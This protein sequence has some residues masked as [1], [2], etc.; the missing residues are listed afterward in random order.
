MTA[1]RY[2]TSGLDEAQFQPG[3]NETV[4]KNLLGI[5][6]RSELEQVETH[7]LLRTTEAMLDHFDQNHRFR[8]EDIRAMH[9]HWLGDIYP[10]AG[11]YRQVMMSKGGFP[12][13]APAFIS[14]LM[15]AFEQEILARHTPCRGSDY[16]VAES[17]AIVH[18]ELVLIHPFRE[19]NGRLAR[20]LAILMGLQ[21]GL[22]MLVFDEMEGERRE[23][24]FAAV[25]AG[26]GQDYQPMQEI[27]RKI[28]AQSRNEA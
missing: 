13:A 6:R 27:F 24:Y 1:D 2:T 3:S 14:K 8:A 16:T 21:A 5:T 11:N 22:P 17:L 18:V 4:L 25:Q 26:L 15:S 10:W 28:I 7:A 9:R 20:L 23:T 19:G 12:F